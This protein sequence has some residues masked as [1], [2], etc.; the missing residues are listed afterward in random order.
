MD[1]GGRFA[2]VAQM[3]AHEHIGD[4]RLQSYKVDPLSGE[5]IADRDKAPLNNRVGQ[6]PDCRL[7]YINGTLR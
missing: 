3:H 1:E 5:A 2:A 4:R 6:D 7:R